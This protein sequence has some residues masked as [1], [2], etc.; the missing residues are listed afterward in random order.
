MI[1]VKATDNGIELNYD[2]PSSSSSFLHPSFKI[3]YFQRQNHLVLCFPSSHAFHSIIKSYCLRWGKRE[4]RNVE[5]DL[6]EVIVNRASYNNK[7]GE[8][9][10]QSTLNEIKTKAEKFLG[11]FVSSSFS[12]VSK[13]RN[14]ERKKVNLLLV[15][16]FVYVF[17]NN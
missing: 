6:K 15:G 14:K 11:S 8:V 13:E 10:A 9:I 3:V 16:A 12:D 5:L 2:A 7:A 17:A 4:K 1:G